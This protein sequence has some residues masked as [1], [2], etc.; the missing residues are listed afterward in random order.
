MAFKRQVSVICKIIIDEFIEQVYSFIYLGY[1]ICY[2][3]EVNNDN[4]FKKKN[5]LKITGIINKVLTLKE[6][7]K[8]N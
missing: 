2:G 1:M 6:N 4:K 7:F 5:Y 8:E 3:R